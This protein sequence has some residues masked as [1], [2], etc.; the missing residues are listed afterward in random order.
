MTAPW[1]FPHCAL[2]FVGG[3]LRVA[4]H[5]NTV[6]SIPADRPFDASKHRVTIGLHNWYTKFHGGEVRPREGGQTLMSQPNPCCN[7]IQR[8]AA[9]F[10][11]GR[12]CPWLA[13]T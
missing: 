2:R 10:V 5:I 12:K 4:P 11:R 13:H 9:S 7:A 6:A 8:A 3:V 1:P